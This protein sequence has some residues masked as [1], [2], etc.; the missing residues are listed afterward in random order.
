MRSKTFTGSC[1]ASCGCPGAP[2]TADP[3]CVWMRRESKFCYHA[4]TK[5]KTLSDVLGPIMTFKHHAS[6][7]IKFSSGSTAA[8]LPSVYVLIYALGY[9]YLSKLDQYTF[10]SA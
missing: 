3:S 9:N 10:A 1:D 4:R 8:D 2:E 6:Q 7:S 5:A